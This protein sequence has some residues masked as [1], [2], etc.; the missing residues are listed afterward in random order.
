M[1]PT[2]RQIMAKLACENT[3]VLSVGFSASALRSAGFSASDV[4]SAGF[5]ASALLSAGFSASALRSA[6][7]SASDVLSAG[8][9]ASAL[10][11]AG[12]SASALRSAGFSASALR[13]AG[14]KKDDLAEWDS[15]PILEKP[16]SKLLAEIKEGKRKHDQATY[17][18]ESDPTTHLCGTRMC[19]AGHLVNMA[20]AIGYALKNK[21]GW[22]NAARLIHMKSRPDVPPQNFGT[23]SQE[24][25]MAYIEERAAEEEISLKT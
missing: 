17:G 6:G 24:F 4:L 15:I 11:S 2:K 14:F 5:S 19:T 8:F 25:A 20:G 13:S 9:S 7:F 21:Y 10:L 16:Y 3:D 18:P 12:F 1:N 23:I 22:A